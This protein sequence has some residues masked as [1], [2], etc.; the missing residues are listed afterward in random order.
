MKTLDKRLWRII[1][2]SKLQFSA[3]VALIFVGLAVFTSFINT[4]A[5][6]SFSLDRYYQEYGFADLFA[7]FTPVAAGALGKLAELP[8]VK[9]VEPRVVADVRADV[10]RKLHP[11]LR[12]VSITPDQ[13]INRLYVREGRLPAVS[14][15]RGIALLTQFAQANGLEVGEKIGLIIRGEV[16][17]LTVTA[18]VDSPEFI[19]AVKDIKNIFPDDLGFG[20]GFVNLPLLQELTGLSGQANNAVF[21]LEPWA[22]A[23]RIREEIEDKFKSLG[24]KG[25]ILREDQLSHAI[26]AQELE[27]LEQQSRLIP[28]IFLS[29]AAAITY[30]TIAR[31]VQSD[32]TTI[33]MLKALGFANRAVVGH[34]LKYALLI[35]FLGAVSGTSTGYLLAG[36]LTGLYSQ[37]FH[38]PLMA[39]RLYYGYF[40]LSIVLSL[41]FSGATGF[42]AALRV[43]HIPPAEAMRPPAPLP[44]RKNTVEKLVPRVWARI[45][46]TWKLVLR[47][48]LRNRYRFALATAGVMLTYTVV[49]LPI[50]FLGLWDTIFQEQFERFERYDY[51]VSFLNPV[52]SR[53]IPEIK[54]L[55]RVTAIEPFAEYPFKVVRGWREEA[56]VARA[57]PLGSELYRFEDE[58]GNLVPL[59]RA[60]VLLSQYLAEALRVQPGDLVELSSYAMRGEK[61]LVPVKAVIKQYLGSGMYMS[62]DQLQRLTG[63]AEN[64][65]G[66]VLTSSEDVNAILKSAGNVVAV[67]SSHDLRSIYEQYASLLIASITVMVLAGG[68]LGFAILLNT[69]NVS[70]TE[71][72]REFSALRVL[73][74]SRE[75]VYGLVLRENAVALLLGLLGGIPLGRSLTVL[76]AMGVNGEL[77]YLPTGIKPGAYLITGFLVVFFTA[78]VMGAVWLRVRRVNFL[79]ALSSRLT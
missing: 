23:D 22:A 58:E 78:L 45:S 32:R 46:F 28:V 66:V 73:G 56:V 17:P 18:L 35:G 8:G 72:I 65:S 60:G 5:N 16:C 43:L 55:A 30:M 50:Y 13:K 34:Y 6:L 74:F 14:G 9:A 40:L 37:F 3:V 10:G 19:Y 67:Y 31:L 26:I 48:I 79:E 69:T 68:L 71:R 76:V 12:L 20:V 29:I 57:L 44:G 64:Y 51:A 42:F 41:A 62:L 61:R 52:S 2:A 27:Q 38:L 11:T 15:E 33:G 1:K 77:F 24:L 7:D 21:L 47:T 63:Q 75:E 54:E 53:I 4:A 70:I 49:L 39:V 25:V 36:G 59:P